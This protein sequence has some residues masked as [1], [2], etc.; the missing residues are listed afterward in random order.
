MT[1]LIHKKYKDQ[2]SKAD[3]VLGSLTRTVYS[4]EVCEL[5][6]KLYY[7]KGVEIWGDKYDIALGGGFLSL[8]NPYQLGKGEITYSDVYSILP[9]DNQLVLCSTTGQNLLRVFINTS[10]DR[11]HVFYDGS[12]ISS[13]D[14]SETY[15][16][17]TDT[18]T[19]TYSYN[20][21]TEVERYQK[22]VYARDLLADCI[23]SGGLK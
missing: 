4:T 21:L 10:N 7:K 1:K 2:I 18:Y 13:I 6:A 12:I 11:Y 23:K 9:F 14:P 8:R 20:N 22:G 17:V 15:F 5:V 19:S 3:E 16:V